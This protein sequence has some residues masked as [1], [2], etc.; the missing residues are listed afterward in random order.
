MGIDTAAGDTQKLEELDRLIEGRWA[1]INRLFEDVEE[2]VEE[3]D[4][5]VGRN[6]GL[7]DRLFG[8]RQQAPAPAGNTTV[9]RPEVRRPSSAK[10]ADFRHRGGNFRAVS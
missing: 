10:S 4:Q 7:L 3:R 6:T 5:L 2:L 1:L 9:R 8:R